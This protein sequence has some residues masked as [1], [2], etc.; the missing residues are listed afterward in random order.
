VAVDRTVVGASMAGERGRKVG[1]ELTGGV[2]KIERERHTC[3]R[4]GADKPSPWSSEKERERGRA[5]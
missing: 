4:N 3:E 5:G 2:G 1:D